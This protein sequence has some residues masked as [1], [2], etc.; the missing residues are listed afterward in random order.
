MRNRN[1]E[2]YD[3]YK[4]PEQGPDTP[5]NRA[6]LKQLREEAKRRAE[7]VTAKKQKDGKKSVDKAVISWTGTEDGFHVPLFRR[8]R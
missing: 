1:M 8:S 6:K 4:V 5:E 3:G 2:E 7:K